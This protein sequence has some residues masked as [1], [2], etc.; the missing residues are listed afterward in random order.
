MQKKKDS[1]KVSCFWGCVAS[2]L[3]A[4][5]R[6]YYEGKTSHGQSIR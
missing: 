4:L 3:V 6:L 2:E 1:E 5:D